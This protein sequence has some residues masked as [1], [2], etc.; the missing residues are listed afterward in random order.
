MNKILGTISF[1]ALTISQVFAGTF[2]FSKLSLE[3]REVLKE[4]MESSLI[5]YDESLDKII[6][7]ETLELELRKSGILKTEDAKKGT[8]CIGGGGGM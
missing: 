4:Y 2:T 1:L 8:Y 5:V 3:E 6:I 7:D